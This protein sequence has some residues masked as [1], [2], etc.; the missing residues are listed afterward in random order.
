MPAKVEREIQR[1]GG[2]VRWRSHCRGGHLWRYAITRK[3]GPRG[4]QVV[5][6]DTGKECKEG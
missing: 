1:R 4:G 2:A 3:A 6:Y 5:A